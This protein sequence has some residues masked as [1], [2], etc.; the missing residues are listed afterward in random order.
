MYTTSPY[1]FRKG[2]KPGHHLVART[3][4]DNALQQIKQENES[5]KQTLAEL[6][7][8]ISGL[9]NPNDSKKK[10]K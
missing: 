4:L 3:P 10:G 9:I 1:G 2:S 5:L 6:Q 7:V 8:Q